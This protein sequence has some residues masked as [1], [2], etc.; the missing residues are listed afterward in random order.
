VIFLE[1]SDH[2]GDSEFVSLECK[3]KSVVTLTL[4]SRKEL[5]SEG[6]QNSKFRSGRGTVVEGLFKSQNSG[7]GIGGEIPCQR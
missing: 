6:F 4:E 3:P 7:R 1:P 5:L 2:F